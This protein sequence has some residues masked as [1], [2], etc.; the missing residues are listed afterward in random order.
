[1]KKIIYL[2]I[3]LFFFLF[4]SIPVNAKKFQILLASGKVKTFN[5]H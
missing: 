2:N 5:R 3:F 1:M 4:I